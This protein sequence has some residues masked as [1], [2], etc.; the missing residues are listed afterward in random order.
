MNEELKHKIDA[1]MEGRPDGFKVIEFGIDFNVVQEYMKLMAKTSEILSPEQL[2]EKA[3]NIH[4]LNKEAQKELLAQLASS[5]SIASYRTLEAF[6]ESQEEGEMQKWSVVALQH[7]RIRLENDLLDEPVGFIA[8]GL[9]GK[10]NKIRYYFI[11]KSKE[12][13]REILL[14]EVSYQYHKLAKDY[15]VEIET[16]EQVEDFISI[17]ILCPIKVEL[18]ELIEEG[19]SYLPFLEDNFVATNMVTPTLEKMKRW[20][21]KKK[22]DDPQ[23]LFNG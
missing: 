17:K 15:D 10:G 3:Q 7:C 5:G 9:G 20:M 21:N 12:V 6:M 4:N 23:N 13:L 16:I 11:L 19:L 22:K 8:T 18:N 14:E 2:E 1:L